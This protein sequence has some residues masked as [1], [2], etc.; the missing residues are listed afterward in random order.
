MRI[1]NIGLMGAFFFGAPLAASADAVTYE[2]TGTVTSATGDYASAGPTISGT[3]II[4]VGAGIPSQSALPVSFES[5]WFISAYG[6][7]TY[8]TAPRAALVFGLTLSSG[9]VTYS[10]IVPNSLGSL[11]SVEGSP[12]ASDE[13]MPTSFLAVNVAAVDE[14]SNIVGSFSLAGGTGANAPFDANGLPIFAN[15]TGGAIGA[16]SHATG[17]LEYTITSLTPVPLPAAAWLLLSGLGGLGTLV[18]RRGNVAA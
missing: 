7:T 18:R 14:N 9:G 10:N 11:S 8:G 1:R 5:I 12:Q 3:Y 13:A 17:V 2:F 6:G 15:A 4:D 16:L